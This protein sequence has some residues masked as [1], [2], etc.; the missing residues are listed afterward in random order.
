MSDKT[1]PQ[2]PSTECPRFLNMGRH[3]VNVNHIVDVERIPAAPPTTRLDPDARQDRTVPAQPVRVKVTL[4]AL[5]LESID[6][7]GEG[8]GRAAA[9]ASQT[10]TV[11]GADAERLW[12]WLERRAVIPTTDVEAAIVAG[13]SV[14]EELAR[15]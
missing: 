8:P 13:L 3:I 9:S 11:R 15:R 7:Y 6:Y 5:E 2:S 14:E 12:A 1:V 10:I 4:T